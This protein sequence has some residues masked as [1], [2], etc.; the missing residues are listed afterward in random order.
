MNYT[1]PQL[2]IILDPIRN[3][4]VDAK[5]RGV[6]LRYLT[7][8]TTENISYCKELLSIVG[9]LRHLD[10]IKG[11]FMISESEYL[12]PAVLFEKGKVAAQSMY[13]NV[14]ELV[15]EHEYTFDTL[16]SKAISAEQRVKEI[17]EGIE[18]IRTRLLE[19][20]DEIIR[21]IKLLNNAANKLSTC[22][23]IGGMQMSYN[24]LFDSYR[25]V[26]DKH[27][28]GESKEGLRWL[29]NIDD[30][31]SA[32]LVEILLKSGMQVR[33]IKSMPPLNFGVSDKEV[34]LAVEKMEGGKLSQSFLISNEPLYVNHFNSLFEQLWKNGIDAADRITDI[35]AGVDLADIEVIPSSARAQ[36]LYLDIVKTASEEILWIFPTTNAFIRQDKIG[37]IQLAKQAAKERNVKVRILVPTNSLIEQ[38]VQKLKEHCPD[39]IIDVRCIEQMTET[40]ATILV[41]DRKASLVMELRD[42]SKRTFVEAIGLST[43]SN[44]K[45]GVLSYVAIFENLWIQS[46]LYEKLKVNDKM[47]KEFI[48]IAAHELRTPI[49]PI[50][51]L[52]QILQSDIG[53]NTKEQEFLDAIV[54]NAKRL[55]RLTENIL[56]VTRIESQSLQLKKERFSLNEIIRNVINDINN[57]AGLRNNN[58]NTVTILFEPKQ[59]V[60]VEADKVRIYEVISNLLKNAIQ[61]T[62]EG[63]ITIV[64]AAEKMDYNDEVLVSIKD[65]GKGIDPEIFPRLFTKFVSKSVAGTGL[66]LFISKS[67]IEAHGGRISAENNADGKGATFYFSL[68]LSK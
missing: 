25:T 27:R 45:A 55:Q 38:K 31:E 43:Y 42:D 40:K 54:R 48:N 8:I 2:A 50:L 4:F 9:E 68:P 7:E 19:N 66:G 20:Q 52:S 32:N 33:H 60:F 17:E 49:Q 18:P 62:K 53:N 34:A 6:R 64:A 59:D 30:K 15:E 14:K 61:F 5:N 58:N 36:D 63:T 12:A 29:T 16:W 35:E 1:R 67:L 56:D 37:A 3:A 28:K 23:A 11:N 26:V 44:S 39:H 22:T 10:G 13:S 51:S 41:V 46:D 65:T 47:Q 57:Q 24:Y 21:E